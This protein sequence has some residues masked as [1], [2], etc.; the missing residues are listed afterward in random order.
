MRGAQR[1]VECCCCS[2]CAESK[3]RGVNRRIDSALGWT[4]EGDDLV[5]WDVVTKRRLMTAV[6]GQEEVTLMVTIVLGAG[7]ADPRTGLAASGM[8]AHALRPQRRSFGVIESETAPQTI[9]DGAAA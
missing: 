4:A 2:L 7:P 1:Q 3:T 8:N 9:R 5:A 6:V